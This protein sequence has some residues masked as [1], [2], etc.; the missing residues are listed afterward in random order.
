MGL[1]LGFVPQPGG[2]GQALDVPLGGAGGRQGEMQ[3][4][5]LGE[6]LP[7]EDRRE[8]AG[9]ELRYAGG[10]DSAR[11]SRSELLCGRLVERGKVEDDALEALLVS[12]AV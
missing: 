2:P 11:V 9:D 7:L 12:I 6:H 10:D 5:V 4:A 3:L 1:G 8:P